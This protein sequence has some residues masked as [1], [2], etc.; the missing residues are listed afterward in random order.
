MWFRP[1]PSASRRYIKSSLTVVTVV[2][3]VAWIGLP[4]MTIPSVD[5]TS[6]SKGTETLQ[7]R[8]DD[9]NEASLRWRDRYLQ[10]VSEEERLAL[11][12]IDA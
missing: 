9:L 11:R 5:S 7:K 3:L 2:M 1:P 10:A 12:S 4:G 6:D 8:L